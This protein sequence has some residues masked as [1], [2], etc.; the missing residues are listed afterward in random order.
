MAMGTVAILGRVVKP[1]SDTDS[2][3]V[4]EGCIMQVG[5]LVYKLSKWVVDNRWMTDTVLDNTEKHRFGIIVLRHHHLVCVSWADTGEDTWE[6]MCN[7][8]KI[9]PDKK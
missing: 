2:R 5:D 1:R 7:L 4:S 9:K 3:N 8:E 6:P